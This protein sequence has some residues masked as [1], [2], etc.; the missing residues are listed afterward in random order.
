MKRLG[1]LMLL[2]SVTA[3]SPVVYD[4]TYSSQRTPTKHVTVNKTY[5][6]SSKH[7]MPAYQQVRPIE[8][9]LYASN[10]YRGVY[11]KPVHLVISD[12][13]YVKVPI[14]N[15]RG[16]QTVIYAH[17]HQK[18]LHFDSDRN[19]RNLHGSAKYK[20][21]KKWDKGH[22]YTYINA[23]KNYDLTGWQ[24]KVRNV[25]PGKL[26]AKKVLPTKKVI[27]HSDNGKHQTKQQLG[28]VQPNRNNK[29]IVV[30]KQHDPAIGRAVVIKEKVSGDVNRTTAR[31]IKRPV[32]V[33]KI[34]L[35]EEVK[36]IARASKENPDK[37]KV[38]VRAR[39][40][41]SRPQV[42]QSDVRVAKNTRLAKSSA[43][44]TVSSQKTS[45]KVTLAG[46]TVTVNG[47]QGKFGKKNLTLKDGESRNVTLVAKG[48]IK[49]NMPIS[50][51]NGTLKVASNGKHFKRDASWSNGK[52]F[53]FSTQ[54]S[55]HLENM[56]LTVVAL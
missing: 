39:S 46:G 13:Q 36:H 35:H 11:F 1:L 23:G 21:D 16:Q 28:N 12:G 40:E 22:K 44:H 27:A 17:Y 56:Q 15:R 41:K 38:V 2:V 31:A 55:S 24:I 48:G 51:S 3:C 19:C 45:V 30:H 10:S 33:E 53:K 7:Y 8:V 29:K 4:A 50:Y 52:T 54:G 26:K 49:I 6:S 42:S 34:N 20:Y 47:K 25:P 43:G 9:T 5:V 32:I 18:S 14:K 37:K